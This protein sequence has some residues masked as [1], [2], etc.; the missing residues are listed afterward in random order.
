MRLD[1]VAWHENRRSG[2]L[3]R[4]VIT[5][6]APGGGAGAIE[7]Q[8]FI[9]NALRGTLVDGH[10]GNTEAVLAIGRKRAGMTPISAAVMNCAG[11]MNFDTNRLID[12]QNGKAKLIGGSGNPA[13]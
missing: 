7:A 9:R 6:S 10:G 1:P 3:R 12:P 13:T 2:Y 11:A 4:Y 5:I 8:H